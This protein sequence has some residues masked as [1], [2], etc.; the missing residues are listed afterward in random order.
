MSDCM[1]ARLSHV[2]F[3]MVGTTIE[4]ARLLLARGLGVPALV[5]RGACAVAWFNR[6]P[7]HASGVVVKVFLKLVG[8][9]KCC[10]CALYHLA[11]VVGVPRSMRFVEY[12][13]PARGAAVSPRVH[14]GCRC[15]CCAWVRAA[16][17]IGSVPGC[18]FDVQLSL[19]AF[20]YSGV[21]RGE[22]FLVRVPIALEALELVVAPY[23]PL[24]VM[25]SP[26]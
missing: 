19:S 4:W 8:V 25:R 20:Q 5:Y 11:T 23:F 17:G 18:A 26:G 3:A 6:P 24:A 12:Q 16:S 1:M 2:P 14:G 13:R 9:A 21:F 15:V 10:F 7:L 22:L